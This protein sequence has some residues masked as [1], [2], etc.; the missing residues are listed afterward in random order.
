MEAGILAQGMANK[1][2]GQEVLWVFVLKPWLS[3]LEA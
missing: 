2:A 3:D 1:A